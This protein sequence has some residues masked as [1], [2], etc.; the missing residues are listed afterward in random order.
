[1]KSAKEGAE[2]Y[3]N[4]VEKQAKQPCQSRAVFKRKEFLS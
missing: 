2:S 4:D 1:M 3:D